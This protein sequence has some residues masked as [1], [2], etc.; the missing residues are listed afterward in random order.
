[1]VHCRCRCSTQLLLLSFTILLL[2]YTKQLVKTV[3]VLP[4]QKKTLMQHGC[5]AMVVCASCHYCEGWGTHVCVPAAACRGRCVHRRGSVEYGT[6]PRVWKTRVGPSFLFWV[7]RARTKLLHTSSWTM[8]FFFV[9]MS[10][11][12]G[13]YVPECVSGTTAAYTSN[14]PR[15][16]CV[17]H[18]P[19]HRTDPH[20]SPRMPTASSGNTTT[21]FIIVFSHAR[22]IQQQPPERQ[23]S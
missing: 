1:M 8:R 23:K 3:W 18:F 5:V 2:T 15:R 13:Q 7:F 14:A 22:F 6:Q 20:N 11:K 17:E 21:D 16:E 19:V 9:S 10:L 12:Y 4:R